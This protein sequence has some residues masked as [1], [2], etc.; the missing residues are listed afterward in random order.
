MSNI[1]FSHSVFYL[2][3]ELSTIYMKI[4]IVV[5]KLS[6]FGRVQYLLF[7][8]GLKYQTTQFWTALNSEHLQVYH[9]II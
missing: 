7:G 9:N 4:K 3:G 6:Q 5:C 1:S 8:K 2:Y